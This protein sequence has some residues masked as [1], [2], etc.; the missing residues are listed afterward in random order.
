MKKIFLALVVILFNMSCYSQQIKVAITD[1]KNTSGNA[2]YNDWGNAMST[3]LISDIQANVSPKRLQLV[4]RGQIDKILKEQKFQKTSFVDKTSIVKIG[5]LLGVNYLLVGEIFVI[6]SDLVINARLVDA[7]TGDIK[8]SKKQEGK[9]TQ[10]LYLKTALAKGLS[11]SISMPFDKPII[12][13]K[14]IS[15]TIINSYASSINDIDNE[16]FEEAKSKI[17]NLLLIDTEFKYAK[18][19]LDKIINKMDNEEFIK[20]HEFYQSFIELIKN[21][22]NPPKKYKLLHEYEL[23]LQELSIL[24]DV[25]LG[26]FESNFRKDNEIA[27]MLKKCGLSKSDYTVDH[28]LKIFKQRSLI[29][30]KTFNYVQDISQKNNEIELN[31]LLYNNEKIDFISEKILPLQICLKYNNLD[32]NEIQFSDN[33][34]IKS[35]N[36]IDYTTDLILENDNLYNESDILKKRYGNF[37]PATLER[38]KRIKELRSLMQSKSLIPSNKKID[39]NNRSSKFKMWF[40]T[41]IAWA[42]LLLLLFLI[43]RFLKNKFLR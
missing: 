25:K 30:F 27:S 34:I 24:L 26:G 10:L 9:L 16:K 19:E 32:L 18:N 13:N 20:K 1:F 40:P 36:I 11:T 42:V 35:E 23:G 33:E 21:E 3:M 4:E 28:M 17:N 43:I 15:P 14:N 2:K 6:N 38:L 7:E 41:I 22:D 5:K 8:F 37:K 29:Y 12:E 31:K 39:K